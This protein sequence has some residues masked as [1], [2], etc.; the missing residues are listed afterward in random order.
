MKK[1]LNLLIISAFVF[2]LSSGIVWAQDSLKVNPGN[3]FQQNKEQLKN[4]IKDLKQEKAQTMETIKNEINAKRQ[5][6][7]TT[8]D[9]AK[10]KI[11]DLKTKIKSEKDTAKA[12]I[13]EQRISGRELAL[14]RFDTALERVTALKDKV[15][16]VLAKNETNGL[17]VTIAKGF[18]ATAETKITD[19]KVK[20]TE[21]YSLLSTSANQL[22]AENK[23]KLQTLAKETQDLILETQQALND[24]IK[25]LK[26]TLQ[27]KIDTL[28]NTSDQNASVENKIE[29][30]STN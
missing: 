4:Q 9:S 18:L 23:V 2:S 27:T 6:M 25:S 3:L 15:S 29:T 28:K 26:E 12:K 10:Q 17:D 14:S 7:Q 20:T 24:S 16:G 8:I 19:A 22:S 30:E 1:Y 13:Q 11:A 5:E 21:A